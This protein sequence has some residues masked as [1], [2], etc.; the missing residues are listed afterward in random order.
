MCAL[1]TFLLFFSFFYSISLLP[2]CAVEA[3]TSPSQGD[4]C[5]STANFPE[6]WQHISAFLSCC[7]LTTMVSVQPSIG[8]QAALATG[9]KALVT[10]ADTLPGS[11][12]D[13]VLM[14]L[15]SYACVCL[16]CLVLH[17]SSR[18]SSGWKCGE[19]ICS[20]PVLVCS[21]AGSATV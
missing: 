21:A 14:V 9:T 18:I 2:A 1:H 7:I 11:P 10:V 15:A 19:S 4:I 12:F 3:G 13:A 8:T 16:N 17:I 5:G 20:E 6:S